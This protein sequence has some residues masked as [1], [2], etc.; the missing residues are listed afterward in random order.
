MTSIEQLQHSI[1]NKILS[2]NSEELL[3]AYNKILSLSTSE[4]EEMIRLN[5]TQLE[6]LRMSEDDIE[7]G[8]MISQEELDKRDS[9]WLS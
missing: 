4:T 1:I 9:E 3:S 8:D 5:A 7:R 2:I 6:M